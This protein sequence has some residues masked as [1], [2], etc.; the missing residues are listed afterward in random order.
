[1]LVELADHLAE[2]DPDGPFR[3]GFEVWIRG[4][5]RLAGRDR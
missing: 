3:F 2:D 4:V 5:E 1:V